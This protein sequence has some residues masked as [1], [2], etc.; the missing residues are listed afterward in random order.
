M[1]TKKY[2]IVAIVLNTMLLAYAAS[3]CGHLPL[4]SQAREEANGVRA[5]TLTSAGGKFGPMREIVLPGAT[6]RE[7]EMLDLETGRSVA[8][9]PFE[10]FKFRA[11]AIMAWIRSKGLDISCNVWSSGAACVTYDMSIVAVNGKCWDEITENE[12]I[13]NPALAPGRHAPR[14]LLVLGG[15]RPDT[16][17]F[18]TGEGTLG[19]LQIVGMSQ[20]RRGVKIRYKLIEPAQSLTNVGEKQSLKYVS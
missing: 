1:N 13:N 18:R 10:R 5:T 7:P 16:Y 12:L 20:D 3:F 6:T 9:E 2:L 19:M 11:A 8:Q 15:N 17:I 14:R 4:Q